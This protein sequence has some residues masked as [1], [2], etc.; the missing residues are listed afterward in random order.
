MSSSRR[1]SMTATLKNKLYKYFCM[2]PRNVCQSQ[3]CLIRSFLSPYTYSQPALYSKTIFFVSHLG[4]L[5]TTQKGPI[6]FVHRILTYLGGLFALNIK[7][8]CYTINSI[9]CC[10]MRECCRWNPKMVNRTEVFMAEKN[11]YCQ[12]ELRNIDASHI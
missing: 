4:T 7:K 9:Y 10:H 11:I 6:L 5:Y 2:Y 3:I 1:L 12:M 8:L